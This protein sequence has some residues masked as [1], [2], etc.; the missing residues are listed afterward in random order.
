MAASRMSPLLAPCV[1]ETFNNTVSITGSSGVAV[2]TGLYY[3]LKKFCNVHVSWSGTQTKT[4]TGKPPLVP[5]PIVVKLNGRIANYALRRYGKAEA[6]ASCAWE[7]LAR[8]VY[9]LDPKALV[10]DH[11]QYTIVVRPSL[12]LKNKTWYDPTEV[13]MAWRDLLRAAAD[14]EIAEQATFRYDL[15]DVTRQSLQLLIDATYVEIRACFWKK[16]ESCFRKLAWLMK[17]LFFDLDSILASDSHFLLGT[18]IRDARS[19]GTTK[20]VWSYLRDSIRDYAAKQWSGLVR[21]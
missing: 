19:W 11:G 14:P 5:E 3:Y 4:A 12:H 15:V 20:E 13:Y 16:M 9:D 8:S 18:W 1:V 17:D 2:A 21:R 7:R 10:K 6:N